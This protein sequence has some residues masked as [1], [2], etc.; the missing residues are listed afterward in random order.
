MQVKICHHCQKEIL[1][2]FYIS[3]SAK[4]TSNRTYNV[5]VPFHRDCFVEIAGED[6]LEQ[7]WIAVKQWAEEKPKKFSYSSGRY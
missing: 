1:E 6:Y 7:L 4:H 2:G 5:E 3:I